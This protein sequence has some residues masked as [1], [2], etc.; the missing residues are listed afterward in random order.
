MSVA[1]VAVRPVER[2]RTRP[3]RW[4]IARH[5]ARSALLW[6]VVWGAVFG[7]LV[8]STVQAFLKGYPTLAQR[9]E[10]A[11]SMQAFV[12]LIGEGHH[13]ETAAGFTSWRLMT[14]TAVIGAIWALRTSTGLLRGE[15]DAGRWE[16]LLAGPTS[17][18]RATLEVLLG[19]GVSL[20]AMFVAT[21]VGVALAARI[22]G[23]RFPIDLGFLFALSLVSSAAMFLAIGTLTSQLAANS[24]Q[25]TM[26]G[27][28]VLGLAYVVRLVADANTS[29]GW[30]RWAS[31]LG[32]I[33]EL[34]PLRDPQ[35]IAL[36]PMSAM[37]AGCCVLTVVLAGRR[38]LN[39]SVLRERESRPGSTRWLS[40]P[41]GL[42]ARLAEFPALIWLIVIGGYAGLLGAVTHSATS[43]IT[44]GSPAVMAALGRLGIRQAAQGYLGLIFLMASVIVALAAASQLAAMRDEEASGRLDNL[45][46]RPC[47]VSS[48]SRADSA[49]RWDSSCSWV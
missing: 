44:S 27:S 11:H 25:A 43:V 8:V 22:P 3:G 9:T 18:R 13:L 47:L 7:L 29:L 2:T 24:G 31:P 19:L 10:L 39:A 34:S 4:V 26:L 15:E 46:V 48:G 16:L 45:L 35:L 32:W 23:A 38:D 6:A 37:I 5:T 28:A 41:T 49:W 14:T 17:A 33:E 40:G 36:V 20:F 21:S 12:I 42:A 1:T 30:L